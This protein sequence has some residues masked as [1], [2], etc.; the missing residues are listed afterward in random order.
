MTKP[1]VSLKIIDKNGR[2][3]KKVASR[4][5]KRVFNFIQAGNFEDCRFYVCVNYGASFNNQ[6]EY[7]SKSN[8]VQALKAFL[9]KD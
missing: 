7:S 9:E 2:A 4:K 8:L 6:G 5:S 3:V 1:F